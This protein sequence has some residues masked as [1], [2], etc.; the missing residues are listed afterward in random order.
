[1]VTAA[2]I[3]SLA[4]VHALQAAESLPSCSQ[5]RIPAGYACSDTGRL[6]IVA[7]PS[8]LS[9]ARSV[10]ENA[11]RAYYGRTG[12][13]S[14]SF[15]VVIGREAEPPLKE[16]VRGNEHKVFFWPSE[17]EFAADIERALER[18]IGRAP[19][20]TEQQRRQA[21]ERVR[22]SV[23]D[24]G[25]GA[26]RYAGIVAHELCHVLWHGD[27][28]RGHGRRDNDGYGTH[29][30][31]WADEVAAI[32]CEP[33]SL[34]AVRR[35]DLARV[36][37]S[38]QRPTLASLIASRHPR[39][40]RPNPHQ[41]ESGEVSIR[42]TV[43]GTQSG[44]STANAFYALLRGFVDFADRRGA[45]AIGTLLR[46]LVHEGRPITME[47]LAETLGANNS[48]DLESEWQSFLESLAQSEART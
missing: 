33:P 44:T 43:R 26:S 37:A 11:Y 9:A 10:A 8:Q 48:S 34:T 19:G 5:L 24:A 1:M 20:F 17:T 29:L 21:L 35:T 36:L 38:G 47:Q 28:E 30:P 22:G 23:L 4:N 32:I 39:A 31:D 45:Q 16:A 41:I 2:L 15:M 46:R 40:S 18:E 12:L 25:S 13:T 14:A 42:V 7:A 3:W 6:R 27:V